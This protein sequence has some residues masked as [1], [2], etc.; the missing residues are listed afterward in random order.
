MTLYRHRVMGPG[1]AGDVWVSTLHSEGAAGLDE[2][3]GAFNAFVNAAIGLHLHNMWATTTAVSQTVTDQLDPLTWKNVAQTTSDIAIQ[4]TS[5]GK[6]PSPRAC[7]VIGLRTVLP[8]RGGRGRMFMPSPSA[9]HYAVTGKFVAADVQEVAG[10][11]ADALLTMRATITPVIA[12]RSNRQWTPITRVT[13]GDIPGTQ[14]RRT[15]KD[16]NNYASMGV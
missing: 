16:V 7:I 14:R 11:F 8:T 10:A 6:A 15:N 12:H 9:D 2:A 4:G 1:S 13:V 5:T 3:H